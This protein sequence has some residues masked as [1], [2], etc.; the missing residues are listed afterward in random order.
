MASRLYQLCLIVIRSKYVIHI[1]H[2]FKN[3]LWG[4][5]DLPYIIPST[6]YVWKYQ[7]GW[8]PPLWVITRSRRRNVMN[9][10]AT[11]GGPYLVVED[12]GNCFTMIHTATRASSWP[13]MDF[14][15]VTSVLGGGLCPYMAYG[16]GIPI[17]GNATTQQVFRV[18]KMCLTLLLL[19]SQKLKK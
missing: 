18:T 10:I 1:H 8:H 19:S 11:I 15:L 2:V 12:A 7:Y 6:Q 5:L 9:H 13:Y 4:V 16:R 14:F 3:C 17:F